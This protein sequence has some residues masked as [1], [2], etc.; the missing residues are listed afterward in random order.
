ML[1]LDFSIPTSKGREAF[2]EAYIQDK[3]FTEKELKTI[4]DYILYGKDEDGTSSV[5]RKEIEIETRYKSYKRK[6]PESLETLMESPAFNESNIVT[7][8]IYK[9]VKQKIDRDRDA[10]I[11]GMKDLWERIDK[12]DYRIK[13]SKGEIEDPDIEPLTGYDLDKAKHRLIE[14]RTEQ[15]VLKDFAKPAMTISPINRYYSEPRDSD[16]DWSDGKYTIAPLGLYSTNPKRFNDFLNIEEYD[17]QYDREAPF[18]LD[19]RNPD[20]IYE[21]VE[22]Y[23][24]FMAAADSKPESLLDDIMETLD[25][26]IGLAELNEERTLILERKKQKVPVVDIQKELKEK[27]NINHSPNY[28]ST[29]YK[30]KICKEIANA[31]TLHYDMYMERD[32]PSS[33]KKCSRCGELKF[34]DSRVFMRKTRSS[35]GYNNKCKKCCN[36]E[37]KKKKE[38]T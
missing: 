27:F 18:I 5:D 33:W 15:Y 21:L 28:I 37:R 20:H 25:F 11:P 34:L 29:I 38:E 30:Q 17:Y 26:Y 14:M 24:E 32:V 4:A 10:D 12:L 1:N 13:V 23:G 22:R 16:T 8:N 3:K 2:I 7:T 35:D 6:R 9:K 31:A 19:F 36:E